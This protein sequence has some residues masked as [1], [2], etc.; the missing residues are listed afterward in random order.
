MIGSIHIILGVLGFMI[1]IYFLSKIGPG[2]G[3]L[4]GGSGFGGCGSGCG[5]CGGGD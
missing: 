5:G 1:L 3:G 4:R 2:T